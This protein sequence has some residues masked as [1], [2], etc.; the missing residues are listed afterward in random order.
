MS[1]N[2]FVKKEDCD[3]LH[4]IC[5][6]IGSAGHSEVGYGSGDMFHSGLLTCAFFCS[7][8][9]LHQNA[10]FLRLS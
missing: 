4:L 3:D 6:G 5:P 7:F 8:R 2:V 9:N 1:E 10:S